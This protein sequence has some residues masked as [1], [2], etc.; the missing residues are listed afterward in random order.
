VVFTASLDD[1]D[2]ITCLE[3]GAD[4]FAVKPVDASEFEAFVAWLDAWVGKRSGVVEI[5]R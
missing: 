5:R 4:H 3:L 2:R 1:A